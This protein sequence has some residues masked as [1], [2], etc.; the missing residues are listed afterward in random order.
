MLV[1][2]VGAAAVLGLKPSTLRSRMQ[3]LEI[4]RPE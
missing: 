2:R 1:G 4:R 3:K